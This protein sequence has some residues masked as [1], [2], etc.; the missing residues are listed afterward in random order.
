[1]LIIQV[2]DRLGAS[3]LNSGTGGTEDPLHDVDGAGVSGDPLHTDEHPET[4]RTGRCHEKAALPT[5]A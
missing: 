5:P 3:D 1:M 4:E 2:V